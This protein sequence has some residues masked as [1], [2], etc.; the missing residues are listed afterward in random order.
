MI[1]LNY[2][3][4]QFYVAIGAIILGI[5][6]AIV[7]PI[8]KGFADRTYVSSITVVLIFAV[9]VQAVSQI[10]NVKMLKFLPV[11]ATILFAVAFALVVFHGTLIITDHYNNLNWQD[12]DY[13]AVVTYCV[14]G[15]L[16]TA[17]SAAVCFFSDK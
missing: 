6:L 3:S 1:K 8:M 15:A 14:L 2:K 5:V 13:N 10:L 12:G 16:S 4:I 11:V 17:F 9:I 7:G